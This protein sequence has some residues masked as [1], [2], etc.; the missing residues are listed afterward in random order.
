[1]SEP[2]R[3][4]EAA[5]APTDRGGVFTGVVA[6]LAL[7]AL[8]AG[9][10]AQEG[11]TVTGEVIDGRSGAPVG[12]AQV[13]LPSLD[14]G[15]LTR[16]NGRFLL[17]DVE[18]GTHEITAERIGYGTVSRTV[19]VEA[20]EVATVDF[21]LTQEAL[22]LEEI[23]VT[24][25]AGQARRR[26]I[27]N[28]VEQL[29]L[30]EEVSAAPVSMDAMLQ[31][32]V[33]GMQVQMNSGQVGDGASIRLRGNVSAALSNNPLLFIDGVRVKSEPYPN[34]VPSPLGTFTRTFVTAT[35]MND[36]NPANIERIEVVK[37]AAATTLYGT[38]AA[39]G[40]V[41]IFTKRGT[42][43]DPVW[44]ASIEQGF[45]RPNKYGVRET[46]RGND[47]EG[48]PGTVS[49]F[50]GHVDYMFHDP[51]L[52]NGHQQQYS[53]SVRGGSEDVSYFLSGQY[54][55][56]E[57]LFILSGAEDYSLQG[58]VN[59]ELTSSIGFDWLTMFTTR[60][61][62]NVPCGN[63]V[64]GV[65]MN[66]PRAPNNYIS[67]SEFEELN[68]LVTM[69]DDVTEI[70]RFLTGGTVRYQ[71][72]G[73]FSSRLALGYDRA[74]MTG[75]I[76]ADY[77]HPS[78]P[79]GYAAVN[80]SVQEMLS[81]DFSSTY[82]HDLSED[83][84]GD[85]STGF[86]YIKRDNEFVE[87]FSENFPGPGEVT[88]STGANSLAR[89]TR[90]L[91]ITGGVFAQAVFGLA[92]RF[93]LT[94]G[95]RVDG[96]SAFGEDFGWETYPK[97][98]A[99]WVVSEETFWPDAL[100]E[101][102]LRGAWGTAGRAPGA[103]DAVR[104]WSPVPWGGEPAFVPENVGNESLGPERTAEIELGFESSLF[105]DRLTTDFTYYRQTTSEALLPVRQTP[106]SGN[107]GTQLENVG[108]LRN[109]GIEI[110]LTAAVVDRQEWGVEVGG[111]VSTNHSEVLDM[112]GA[113]ELATGHNTYIV[114][115]EPLP[116]VRGTV[117]HSPNETGEPDITGGV[118][119]GP[120]VPTL[121]VNPRLR[122][123]LPHGIDVRARGD[124]QGGHYVRGG[125]ARWALSTGA[126]YPICWDAFELMD[127]GRDDELTQK[128]QLACVR[129]N[130]HNDHL[131]YP[132]DFFKLREVSVTVPIDFVMPES[133]S[134][135]LTLSGTNLWR[136]LNDDFLDYDPESTSGTDGAHSFYNGVYEHPAPP[137]NYSATVRV[138]F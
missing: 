35:P 93:F 115:G 68:K 75:R 105:S 91:V 48:Y 85:F 107:W 76:T 38:E 23:V 30:D 89:E 88:L 42:E 26:E 8:P 127:Q 56:R 22:G 43:G 70:D 118:N 1:M 34:L 135:S 16:A 116:V 62:K 45:S 69:R 84:S 27:G 14:R 28:T 123:R 6:L 136:W 9:T 119:L 58:N 94:T 72:G 95:L 124:Y 133:T 39:S 63:N 29:T 110:G 109:S 53:T 130:M 15:G 51:W 99:S 5:E 87:G 12:S 104:T 126:P 17:A 32:R 122:V 102:Q 25:T 120:N 19:E 121:M 66:A 4:Q 44:E 103:F 111:D 112:G 52:R 37:G 55:D 71:P 117:F 73:D 24:G 11:G 54:A 33:P 60:D 64:Q 138:Q 61:I 83:V 113:A 81:V 2:H 57:N 82:S 31:G 114:E 47:T 96:N 74:A 125:A 79:Q 97:V 3:P 13:Y 132:A 41:Q 128:E 65:C 20:G 78:A 46:L 59:L 108:E 7:L 40:V 92:D 86:Q 90:S 77:G 129:E 80:E 101:M 18:P 131:I 106:S 36:I 50:G 100:G 137:Q 134:A 98:S 49:D 10:L 67:S 21:E